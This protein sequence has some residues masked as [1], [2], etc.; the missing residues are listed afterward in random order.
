MCWVMPPASPATTLAERILSSR[1]VLPWSTW[2]MTVMTGGRDALRLLVV[3]V[4]VVEEGLELHLLLLARFH[5]EQ[6]GAHLEGEQLHL[7]VR[8]RHGG[9]DHLA[10]LEQE[11][12]DVGR[13]AVELG[14]ELLGRRASLDDDGALGDRGVVGRVA[15]EQLLGL[16]L[17]AVAT[18]A[19]APL[20]LRWAATAATRTAGTT[21]GTTWATGS[22]TGPP[23]D[24]GATTGSGTD[25]GT[26]DAT[27]G[28]AAGTGAGATGPGAGT[29]RPSR[30]GADRATTVGAG[31]RGPPGGGGMGRPVCDTRRPPGGGGM[32]LPVATTAADRAGAVPA[33]GPRRWAGRC[34]GG[35]DRRSRPEAG[36]GL[37]VAGRGRKSVPD[38]RDRS[39]PP[40]GW[41]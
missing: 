21:A 23:G 4:V 5:Q 7:L 31:G 11:A 37:G 16:Q 10:L 3:V 9:G 34:P 8:Q 14:R 15:G 12:D 24:P 27:T 17:L 25:A 40:A 2:P 1:V 38:R 19:T 28:R 29:T 13:G 20:A 30:A 22:T 41:R 32:G 6:L 33:T 36:P 39:R 18:P 35:P 26:A